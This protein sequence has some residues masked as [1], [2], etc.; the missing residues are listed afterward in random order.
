M[1]LG[2]VYQTL[3]GNSS[4]WSVDSNGFMEN[5]KSFVEDIERACGRWEG[6]FRGYT[7][8]FRDFR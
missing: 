5:A 2:L 4:S 7:K 6:H 8:G 3:I 1:G